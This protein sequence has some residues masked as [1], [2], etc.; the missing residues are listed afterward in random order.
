MTKDQYL[1]EVARIHSEWV[2]DIRVKPDPQYMNNNPSQYPENA[3]TVSASVEDDDR[4]WAQI[5]DLTAR[6]HASNGIVP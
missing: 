3:E 4:Y 2:K 1:A 5:E 6:Y